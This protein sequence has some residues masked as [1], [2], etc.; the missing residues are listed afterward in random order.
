MNHHSGEFSSLS[1]RACPREDCCAIWSS[2]VFIFLR[3]LS[4]SNLLMKWSSSA[5]CDPGDWNDNPVPWY[6]KFWQYPD[7]LTST[8]IIFI[9]GAILHPCG[10]PSFTTLPCSHR[11][12]QCSSLGGEPWFYLNSQEEYT[13]RKGEVFPA[14]TS[15]GILFRYMATMEEHFTRAKEFIPERWGLNKRYKVR[16]AHFKI[17]A[18]MKVSPTA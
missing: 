12:C 9:V 5:I 1:I 13:T 11:T 10:D 7:S 18:R 8:T 17:E 4:E 3:V 14:G 15:F 16:D 6:M 2:I